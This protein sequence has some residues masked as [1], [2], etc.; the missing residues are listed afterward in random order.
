VKAFDRA[1]I[2]FTKLYWQKTEICGVIYKSNLQENVMP[3]T[4]PYV[5]IENV[6]ASASVDQPIDLTDVTKKFPDTEWHPEQFPGLVFR[7]KSPKTATL[8]FR[9]G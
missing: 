8:I 4:K 2:Q 9:S 5:S 3:A 1:A 7:L 6:V